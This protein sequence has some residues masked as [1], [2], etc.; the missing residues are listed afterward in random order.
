MILYK[1]ANFYVNDNYV[2]KIIVKDDLI[3]KIG[4]DCNNIVVKKEIDLNGAFV[5]PGFKDSHMHLLGYGRKL[6]SKNIS[7]LKTK[8]E[9]LNK[10][11]QL[12]NNDTLKIEGYFNYNINKFDLDKISKD[13]YII[14]RH[15]DYHS[16]TVNSKVLNELNIKS[17]DGIILNDNISKLINPLW[18]DSSRK[19]LIKYGE[20]AIES[21]IKNG[22][23]SISTDDLSYFNSYKETVEILRELSNKY[24]FN[25]NTLI[26]IDIL[27]DYLKYFQKDKYIKDIGIKMFY[28][29]TLSSKTAYIS[30]LYDNNDNGRFDNK[31]FLNNLK[32][33]RQINKNILVH[34][35]GDLALNDLNKYLLKD[36]R[37]IH[38]SLIN[39]NMIENLN[40]KHIDIQPLFY[41]TDNAILKNIKDFKGLIH[42]F[43]ELNK[44][45]YILN[46]S[47]DAPVESI[48]IFKNIKALLK[49]DINIKDIL[50]MYTLNESIHLKDNSG[51]IK[52]N[53]KASFTCFN[54]D[55]LKLNI[56]NIKD[57]KIT[58]TIVNNVIYYKNN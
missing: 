33:V 40:T 56:N 25:I 2:N 19:Q 17:N 32:R 28:D 53:F 37:L 9:V 38:A 35:I 1:N 42:P 15:N 29:G 5:Y 45:G 39:K 52:E 44:N 14:L 27:D 20:K 4:D 8:E 23:T 7:H 12:Y 50:K 49:R 31:S 34:V 24:K 13:N 43:K 18:E 22:I 55:I 10:I 16:F 26:N 51:L 54:K 48:N 58:Y 11:R 3:Y 36:D 47:S 6:Y 46:I 21:L 41:D 57:Y 30:G